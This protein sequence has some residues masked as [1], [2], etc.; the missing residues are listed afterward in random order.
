MMNEQ[1]RMKAVSFG[2]VKNDLGMS[3]LG[4]YHLSLCVLAHIHST[5]DKY[6]HT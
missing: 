2:M 3:S 6:T 1:H 4:T 5:L